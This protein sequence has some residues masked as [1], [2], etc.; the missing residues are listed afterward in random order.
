ME[1]LGTDPIAPV[2]ATKPDLP[3]VLERL[4]LAMTA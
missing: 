1:R 2:M 3:L 4:A